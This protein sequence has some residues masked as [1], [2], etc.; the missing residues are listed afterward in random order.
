MGEKKEVEGGAKE[1]EESLYLA[2]MD[3]NIHR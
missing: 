1:K 3:S 2:D